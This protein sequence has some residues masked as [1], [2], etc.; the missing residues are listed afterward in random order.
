MKV[1]VR[2]LESP[3]VPV[4]LQETRLYQQWKQAE[5]TGDNEL[6]LT[7]LRALVDAH[8]AEWRNDARVGTL[9]FYLLGI[10]VTKLQA[11]EWPEPALH[12]C[13]LGYDLASPVDQHW[14]RLFTVKGAQLC[15]QTLDFA[16]GQEVIEGL[17][18]LAPG[19]LL[20]DISG[21]LERVARM[22][23]IP[24][25]PASSQQIQAETLHAIASC[26]AAQGY[27][28]PAAQILDKLLELLERSDHPSLSMVDVAIMRIEFLVDLGRFEEAEAA[29]RI[30]QAND[31]E[32]LVTV[33]A[34]ILHSELLR[35]QGRFSEALQV[36]ISSADD[37]ESLETSDI[38][39]QASLQRINILSSLNRLSEAEK[40]LQ[41]TEKIA[42]VSDTK[43]LEL[44]RN[45]LKEKRSSATT[46]LIPVPT[47]RQIFSITQ[48]DA[49]SSGALAPSGAHSQPHLPERRSTRIH[50]DVARIINLI[51][52]AL[53]RD[54]TDTAL[55]LA[56]QLRRWARSID[57]PLIVAKIEY[58]WA[59][60]AYSVNDV[61]AAETAATDCL[62]W[63]QQFHMLPSAW[64]A[65]RLLCWCLERRQALPREIKSQRLRLAGLQRSIEQRQTGADAAVFR[66][67]KWST[68]DEE[69]A[70]LLEDLATGRAIDGRDPTPRSVLKQLLKLRAMGIVE[71]QDE[72]WEPVDQPTED[73]FDLM[74]D[75][76]QR[77]LARQGRLG[78]TRRVT[79][80]WLPADTAV[81]QFFVLPD[82]VAIFV[83]TN[84]ECKYVVPTRRTARP[85]LWQF[86]HRAQ[87]VLRRSRWA[88]E[89]GPL[90]LLAEAVAL[91]DIVSDLPDI[92]SRLVII[93]DDVLGHAPFAALPVYGKP[94]VTHY[95]IG[96]AQ[97]FEWY[98]GRQH[99]RG[100]TRRKGL[101]VAVRE[102]PAYISHYPALDHCHA[103]I[104]VA[105]AEVDL[106]WLNLMDRDA[107]PAAVMEGLENVELAH[108]ACHGDF[109]G[110]APRES[111]LLLYDRWL[112]I[113][114]LADQHFRNLQLVTLAS[115]WGAN[116]T[117]LP[118]SIQIGLPSAFI[119]AGA[120]AVVASLW[121]VAD[122]SASHFM[123]EFYHADAI[124]DP[125]KALA[126]AQRKHLD[127]PPLDWAGYMVFVAGLRPRLLPHLLLWCLAKIGL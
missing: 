77:R 94:L 115:C 125:V 61:G 75:A 76:T 104:Q 62:A 21:A 64:A 114:D 26:L 44:V 18:D 103:E 2:L 16:A 59:L 80:R 121:T 85:N 117:R 78:L 31:L 34:G 33:K 92:V 41:A 112:R 123:H 27:I 124:A 14:T 100:L 105:Q 19:A 49:P 29:I 102:S 106:R 65:Q 39:V 36:S 108:F 126:E 90:R 45:I 82:R 66:L 89:R 116:A 25:D 60:T 58:A 110:D 12:Y 101:A 118:G 74:V 37:P 111:G 47:V 13:S 24:G 30:L 5:R 9:E 53:H 38:L 84:Q 52:L 70:V 57:S 93:A 28:E 42:D 98:V 91:E 8:D 46:T 107:T 95:A 56:L 4:K 43:M 48:V 127:Q 71:H 72:R 40:L 81:L 68:V 122:A 99:L 63:F 96:F 32:K 54:E 23:A 3:G 113:A 15:I 1:R 109:F 10:L 35:L 83:T 17:L 20:M 55:S 87:R 79:G 67:N 88:G 11:R 120:S 6:A 119:E 86:V 97:N 51:L 73:L 50:G 7:A 22:P 69:I